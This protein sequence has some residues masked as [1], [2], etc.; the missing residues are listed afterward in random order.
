M[1]V[2]TEQGT[3]GKTKV[4]IVWEP[5][6]ATT[7]LRTEQAGRVTV[8]AATEKGDLVYR[9]RSPE[10]APPVTGSPG[11]PALS[12]AP[13]RVSFDAPPGKLEL[14]MTIEG[15]AGGTLDT[16]NRVISVP[17]LTGP[18]AALS[19]PRVFRARTA[20]DFTALLQNAAA[21]PAASREFSRTERL[22]VRF[23]AYGANGD[24]PDVAAALL[25]PD[26]HK[27]ADVP[28]APAA[29]GGTHQLDLG[30]NT[31]AAGEYVLQITVK[32]TSGEPATEY[33]PFRIGA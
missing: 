3:G 6:A 26:G 25:A 23:D 17:D 24:K 18:V 28:V 14:R 11:N 10:G 21:V 15:A 13:Q 32:G 5:L 20:R 7:G 30:L 1:W 22:L 4:S 29:A 27:V 8:L 2:G 16:E 33:V 12:T 19:T 9:G 31:L